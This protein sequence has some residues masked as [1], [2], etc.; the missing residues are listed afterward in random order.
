MKYVVS[1]VDQHCNVTR[2][3]NFGGKE[4]RVKLQF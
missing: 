3:H 4:S 2:D 1:N